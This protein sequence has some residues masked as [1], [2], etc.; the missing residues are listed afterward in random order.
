M[1]IYRKT[2]MD[3]WIATTPALTITEKQEGE[4]DQTW[5]S[6]STGKHMNGPQKSLRLQLSGNIYR[7]IGRAP[8]MG[9]FPG[10]NDWPAFGLM[11]D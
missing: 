11:S 2:D 6:E 5:C 4:V 10:A 7:N 1:D 8:S 9:I 3:S